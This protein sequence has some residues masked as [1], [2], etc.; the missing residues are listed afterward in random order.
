MSSQQSQQKTLQA[1]ARSSVDNRRSVEPGANELKDVL[2]GLQYYNSLSKRALEASKDKRDES[3]HLQRS[4]PGVFQL[5]SA[6]PE[7][8][9]QK[10]NS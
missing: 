9:C 2:Q 8:I 3:Q 5:K 7:E 6:I 1:P 4:Y 10:M